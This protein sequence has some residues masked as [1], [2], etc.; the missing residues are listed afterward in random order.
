LTVLD[1]KAIDALEG[2][3]VEAVVGEVDAAAE[4]LEKGHAENHIDGYMTTR[5]NLDRAAFTVGKTVIEG[6]VER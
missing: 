5:W 6:D 2:R 4:R 1:R 3:G